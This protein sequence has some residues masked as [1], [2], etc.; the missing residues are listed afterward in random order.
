MKTNNLVICLGDST[1]EGSLCS[2]PWPQR[3]R[4]LLGPN[5]ACPNFGH[6]GILASDIVTNYTTYVRHKSAYTTA[7]KCYVVGIGGVNDVA[8]GT[9][10]ATIFA[11]MKVMFDD[12]QADAEFTGGIWG[13]IL[14]AGRY[15]ASAPKETVLESVNTSILSYTNSLIKTID[16]WTPLVDNTAGQGYLGQSGSPT[17]YATPGTN[18]GTVDYLHP[19]DTAHAK[20]AQLI[21]ALIP[22]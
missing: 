8:A 1:T 10:A 19:N 9:A 2:R 12:I 7:P 15:L 4:A 18:L 6:I 13:T 17:D 22:H 14:P 11:N 5:W 21:A 3:L 20:I 16:L